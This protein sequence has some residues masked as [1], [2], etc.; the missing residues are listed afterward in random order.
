MWCSCSNTC[1]LSMYLFCRCTRPDCPY[2]HTAP[3]HIAFQP[4]GICLFISITECKKTA[5]HWPISDQSVKMA[6]Q[7]HF[8]WA[9]FVQSNNEALSLTKFDF[10][11]SWWPVKFF[12]YFVPCI[13]VPVQ[14]IHICNFVCK[15][16]GTCIFHCTRVIVT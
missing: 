12:C 9:I 4:Q 14:L 3:K 7:T 2:L 5:G 1:T 8:W 6:N 11:W 10:G 15:C 16:T 13:T